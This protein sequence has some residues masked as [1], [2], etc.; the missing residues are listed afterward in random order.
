MIFINSPLVSAC[1]SCQIRHSLRQMGQCTAGSAQDLVDTI[2]ESLSRLS[3]L[4]RLRV[5]REVF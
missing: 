5:L 3:G 4:A 2:I 1:L